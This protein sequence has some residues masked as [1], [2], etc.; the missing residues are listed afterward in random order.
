MQGNRELTVL[1]P[2]FGLIKLTGRN[3]FS[4]IFQKSSLSLTC[5]LAGF[6][7]KAT[8]ISNTASTTWM[9]PPTA[10]RFIGITPGINDSIAWGQEKDFSLL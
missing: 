5:R 6:P 2:L 1:L 4:Q 10:L 9:S 7:G 3:L 8:G